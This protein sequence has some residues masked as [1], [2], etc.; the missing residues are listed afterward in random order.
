MKAMKRFE[1]ANQEV[2]EKYTEG[3]I[4]DVEY[5]NQLLFNLVAVRQ[6]LI[7]EGETAVERAKE[8]LTDLFEM[9][10]IGSVG[11]IK[12]ETNHVN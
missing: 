10:H 12:L 7:V 4:T 11:Q 3:L 1:K 9:P 5:L 2:S 6:D 8:S